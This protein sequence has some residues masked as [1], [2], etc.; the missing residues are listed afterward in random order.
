MYDLTPTE[1]RLLRLVIQWHKEH[2]PDEDIDRA[3]LR[4][5]MGI[6]DPRLSKLR[7]QL[8][9]K[10]YLRSERNSFFLND[11]I[12]TRIKAMESKRD[13]NISVSLPLAG[14]VRG[15]YA[16]GDDLRVN[17]SDLR[18]EHA[19]TIEVPHLDDYSGAFSLQVVGDS[20]R[21]EGIL[22]GDYAI[23]KPFPHDYAPKQRQLIVTYYLPIANEEYTTDFNNPDPDL[24][25]GP[26][27]KYYT[28]HL[29]EERPYRLAWKTDIHQ[30]P[31]TIHTRFISAVGEVVGVYCAIKSY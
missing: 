2:G 19:P 1:R 6:E 26:T 28:Y 31:Y 25:Y 9:Q 3:W 17:L 10:R 14:E 29:N 4:D 24:L 30:S 5:E 11:D 15:G 12:E 7:N 20:M 27:I 13:L 21:H 23:V 18:D 22:P 16:R 8:A